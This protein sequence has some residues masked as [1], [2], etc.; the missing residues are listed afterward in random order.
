LTKTQSS[1][2]S[3]LGRVT[4][5]SQPQTRHFR[6]ALAVISPPPQ[7]LGQGQTTA[8]ISLRCIKLTT[9]PSLLA[10]PLFPL[11]LSKWCKYMEQ[12]LQDQLRASPSTHNNKT[13]LC[14]IS[15]R[16]FLQEHHALAAV[17]AGGQA[18]GST[19]YLRARLRGRVDVLVLP[20]LFIPLVAMTVMHCFSSARH[21]TCENVTVNTYNL[22]DKSHLPR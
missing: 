5:L 2:P 16:H 10:R 12:I 8:R 22:L 6:H 3:T 19:L 17:H 20:F 9:F 1:K 13:V 11:P 14:N 4:S 15:H 21:T 18:T 7:R